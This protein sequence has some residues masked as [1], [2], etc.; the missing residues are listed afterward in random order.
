MGP[1]YLICLHF[2][3]LYFTWAK[4]IVCKTFWTIRSVDKY[5]IRY[6]VNAGKHIKFRMFGVR[7]ERLVEGCTGELE[8]IV[9]L[10]NT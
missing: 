6:V 1:G 2:V 8:E 4:S 7:D 3:Y 9:Y 10:P 5:F